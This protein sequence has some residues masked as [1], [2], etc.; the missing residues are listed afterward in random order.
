MGAARPVP[1]RFLGWVVAACSIGLA[2]VAGIVGAIDTQRTCAL[3]FDQ[4]CDGPH[5]GDALI[6]FGIAAVL[7]AGG[8]ALVVRLRRSAG[9]P[10]DA[11]ADR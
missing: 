6:A 9:T 7:L 1:R 4:A 8:V 2:C 10:T 11:G 3:V 5:W